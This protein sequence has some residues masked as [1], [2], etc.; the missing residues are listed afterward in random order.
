MPASLTGANAAKLLKL[1]VADYNFWGES[2]SDSPLAI[3]RSKAVLDEKKILSLD[4]SARKKVQL[5]TTGYKAPTRKIVTKDLKTVFA[6][7]VKEA[8]DAISG[9]AAIEALLKPSEA[10][11][12]YVQLYTVFSQLDKP[13]V[14]YVEDSTGDPY[15]GLFIAGVSSDGETV[16]AEALLTQT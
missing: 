9:K 2:E 4:A 5:D 11:E 6:P 12:Y 1:A 13:S 15:T 10:L 3:K 14:Y 8:A 7:I 16:F